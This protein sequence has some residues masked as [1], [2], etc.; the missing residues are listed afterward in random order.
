MA[1][2]NVTHTSDGEKYSTT[3]IT[4]TTFTDA[5]VNFSVRYPNEIITELRELKEFKK[6][7]STSATESASEHTRTSP[8]RRR[9]NVWDCTQAETELSST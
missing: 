1:K 5:Y 2:W 9:I 8:K 6:W 7:N 4:G 3:T